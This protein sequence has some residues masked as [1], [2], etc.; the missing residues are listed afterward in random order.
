LKNTSLGPLWQGQRLDT[1]ETNHAQAKSTNNQSVQELPC[2]YAYSPW[3]SA[4]S[5]HKPVRSVPKTGQTYLVQQTT[6]PK[7]KCKRNA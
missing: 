5:G 2:T 1:S 7:P 4:N 3:T 6:P